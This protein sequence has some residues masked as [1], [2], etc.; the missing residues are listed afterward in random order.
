M[1]EECVNIGRVSFEI[2]WFIELYPKGRCSSNG[3]WCRCNRCLCHVLKLLIQKC[4]LVLKSDELG[5]KSILICREWR[6][7][8]W[9]R[10]RRDLFGHKC[11]KVDS[12]WF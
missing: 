1:S 12:N 6:A 10:N 7:H 5:N 2:I 8:R 11:V 3:L 4:N 9:L